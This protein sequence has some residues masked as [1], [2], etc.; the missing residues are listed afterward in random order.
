V[1][2]VSRHS[3]TGGVAGAGA[4]IP[5]PSPDE[6]T[7]AQRRVYEMVVSGPRGEMI[8][9]LRA[10]IHNPDLAERWS[11]L[12]ELLRYG[13]SLPPRCT[14][15]AILVTAR[16]WTSQLEWWA[17]ARAALEAGLPAAIVDDIEKSRSPSFEDRADWEIYEF[18]RQLQVQGRTDLE[19]Y[20]AVERRWGPVGVVELAALIGY[21]TMVAM[22]LNV[23]EIPLPAGAQPV[24]AAAQAG[25]LAAVP[26][27]DAPSGRG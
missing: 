26:L 17:H 9:P 22:T 8:G 12:G 7:A 19:S 25:H 1:T 18:A 10:A 21:Y 3:G 24:L 13:T 5:L 27:A 2:E 4:R 20:R 6:M 11:R 14:E 16:R 23:H 15:L